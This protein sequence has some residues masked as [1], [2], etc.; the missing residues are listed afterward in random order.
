M[1]WLYLEFW[2]VTCVTRVVCSMHPLAWQKWAIVFSPIRESF[3]HENR[4]F[5]N[6]WKFSPSKVLYIS[7]IPPVVGIIPS[8]PQARGVYSHK[9]PNTRRWV[10]TEV[11][12]IWP[13]EGK[14]G[15]FRNYWFWV[16]SNYS[17]RSQFSAKAWLLYEWVHRPLGY[18]TLRYETWLYCQ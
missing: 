10:Y 6:T 16:I 17:H 1:S 3:L 9:P 14:P 13:T 11:H 7:D 8:G 5:T 2:T 12:V 15:T 4:I 18:K